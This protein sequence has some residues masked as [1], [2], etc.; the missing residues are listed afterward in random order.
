MVD[1]V[2]KQVIP[3]LD[4][5]ELDDEN[6]NRPDTNDFIDT[7]AAAYSLRS[8]GENQANITID[9]SSDERDGETGKFVVQTRRNVDGATKSFTAADVT[10]G[11]ME[12]FVEGDLLRYESDFS[13]STDGFNAVHGTA[14]VVQQ[15][16]G[17]ND[18]LKFTANNT[19]Q[20]LRLQ[21]N[22]TIKSRHT[23]KIT[24]EV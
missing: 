21:R 5:R 13:S 14:E 15:A 19:T 23:Y 10:D 9:D 11:T 7:P 18:C 17:K 4:I 16:Y 3:P 6:G 2:N 22:S 1:W 8:L 20:W 12:S 24:A